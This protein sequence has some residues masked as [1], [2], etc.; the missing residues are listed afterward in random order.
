MLKNIWYVGV[1]SYFDCFDNQIHSNTFLNVGDRVTIVAPTG[2][3]YGIGLDNGAVRCSAKWNHFNNC[4]HAVNMIVDFFAGDDVVVEGNTFETLGGLFLT[5]R[6]GGKRLV[7]KDNRGDTCGADFISI[8][9]DA[10]NNAGGGYCENPVVTGNHCN[11]FNTGNYSSSAGIVVTA[12]GHKVVRGNQIRHAITGAT[13]GCIGIN[14]NGPA[15]GGSC[16]STVEENYLGGNFPNYQAILFNVESNFVERNNIIVGNGTGE[17][18]FIASASSNGN[19]GY[20]TRLFSVG[21]EYTNNS[22]TTKV[23]GRR[24]SYVPTV[25]AASGGFSIGNGSASGEYIWLSDD[26]VQVVAQ[27]IV[28]S[29]TTFGSGILLFSLPIDSAGLEEIGSAVLFGASNFT[30]VCRVRSDNK[31]DFYTPSGVTG[32]SP[33]ALTTGNMIKFTVVYKTT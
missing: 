17:G 22:T 30:G 31:V 29:T 8:S 11:D 16:S 9:A 25:T 7:V 4:G 1:E 5:H 33:A 19:V 12:N 3:Y 21:N 14:M 13:R 6:N 2:L 27:I 18:V 23:F 26:S 24:I 10:G 32:S 20:G 15:P 28:G